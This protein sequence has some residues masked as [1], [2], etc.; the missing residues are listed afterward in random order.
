MGFFVDIHRIRLTCAKLHRRRELPHSDTD[1][2]YLCKPV[3]KCPDR[4]RSVQRYEEEGPSM[5]RCGTLW[6]LSTNREKN[7]VLL[8]KVRACK[9]QRCVCFLSCWHNFICSCVVPSD[10][11]ARLGSCWKSCMSV[12]LIY[13]LREGTLPQRKVSERII[14]RMTHRERLNRE[15]V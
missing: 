3:Q 2:P 1:I 7:Q 5:R 4:V 9:K 10:R 6:P 12:D 11:D 14:V 13:H 15:G 8:M